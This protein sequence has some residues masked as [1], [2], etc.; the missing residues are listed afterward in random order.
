MSSP[1]LTE[2]RTEAQRRVAMRRR[3]DGVPAGVGTRLSDRKAQVRKRWFFFRNLKAFRCF[4][5]SKAGSWK[6]R[7]PRLHSK[8]AT[9][10]LF[11][12][13]FK[14]LWH[15]PEGPSRLQAKATA[16]GAG[17][18][19]PS[20]GRGQDASS[21]RVRRGPWSVLPHPAGSAGSLTSPCFGFLSGAEAE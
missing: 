12:C 13:S 14:C 3:R 2:A 16:D 15:V 11:F 10:P 7:K 17:T 1:C 6:Q 4:R 21:G 8:H 20:G 19:P 18:A 5:C 9:A